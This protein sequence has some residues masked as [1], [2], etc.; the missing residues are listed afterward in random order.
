M[1]ANT[2]KARMEQAAARLDHLA[3]NASVLRSPELWERYHEAVKITEL[4]G[5]QVAQSGG[6]RADAGTGRPLHRPARG[7]VG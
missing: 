6:R 2:K 7:P 3:G 5:F 4:L 1:A